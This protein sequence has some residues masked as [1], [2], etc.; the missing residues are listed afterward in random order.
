MLF[1]QGVALRMWVLGNSAKIDDNANG[2]L[3]SK[4]YKKQC[5]QKEVNNL[6]FLN[7]VLHFDL[8]LLTCV[9]SYLYIYLYD[10]KRKH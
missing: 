9:V 2:P 5:P 6:A 8:N 1:M 10:A 3:S 4:L 7:C